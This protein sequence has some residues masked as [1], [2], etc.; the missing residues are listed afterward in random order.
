MILPHRWHLFTWVSMCITHEKL[1]LGMCTPHLTLYLNTQRPPYGWLHLYSEITTHAW[2]NLYLSHWLNTSAPSF[3]PLPTCCKP[4]YVCPPLTTSACLKSGRWR[5]RT[6]FKHI[7]CLYDSGSW[8]WKNIERFRESIF[9]PQPECVSLK[10]LIKR[11]IL[12]QSEGREE[13]KPLKSLSHTTD[14][15]W[16]NAISILEK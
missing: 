7:L 4:L 15:Q 14:F 8:A 11:E 5:S 10:C 16:H 9:A 3:R 12:R 2:P 6:G 13:R 1:H